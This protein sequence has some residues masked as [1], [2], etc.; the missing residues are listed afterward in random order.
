MSIYLNLNDKYKNCTVIYFD[1]TIEA[2]FEDYYDNFV[3]FRDE[4]YN[5][6]SVNC[7]NYEDA[8]ELNNFGI[9]INK[10]NEELKK[11]LLSLNEKYLLKEP[12]YFALGKI[13]KRNIH[14]KS[15]KLFVLDVDFKDK[16]L[17]IITNT[18]YTL[19][20]KYFIWCLP[21][22]ITSKGTEIKLGELMGAK[23]NGML[24]TAE[25]LD[26]CEKRTL[27]LNNF[28]D[29]CDDTYL[30]ESIYKIMNWD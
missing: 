13:I 8:N 28:L 10:C 7:L 21:G 19:E 22:S 20:G 11:N 26:L 30:G 15:D 16:Q 3:V 5:V 12:I 6:K 1:S 29:S 18:T 9:L 24:C 17:Q 27:E 2:K 14:P 25:S 4:N 23:S